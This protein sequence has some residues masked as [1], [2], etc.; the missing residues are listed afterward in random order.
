KIFARRGHWIS[1]TWKYLIW[2]SLNLFEWLYCFKIMNRHIL[3]LRQ[4]IEDESL[5]TDIQVDENPC[6]KSTGQCDKTSNVEVVVFENR[7]KK[8]N[9]EKIA[10]LEKSNESHQETKKINFHKTR[11]EVQ[12]F[13]INGFAKAD[14]EKAKI[15]FAIKLGAKPP[16]NEYINYKKLQEIKKKEKRQSE[17]VDD[18][19]TLLTFRAKKRTS[20]INKNKVRGFDEAFGKVKKQTNRKSKFKHNKK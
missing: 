8:V 10:T 5:K 14:K 16:K 3:E 20:K 7:K 18:H 15:A 4:L 6:E 9:K 11:F 13:G 2:R 12:K 17:A 19:H 1:D